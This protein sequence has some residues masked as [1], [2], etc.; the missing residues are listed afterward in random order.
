MVYAIDEESDTI[1]YFPFGRSSRTRGTGQAS[2]SQ[3]STASRGHGKGME[4]AQKTTPI[5]LM[6]AKKNDPAGIR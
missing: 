2:C 6:L 3:N 5:R 4:V 1:D